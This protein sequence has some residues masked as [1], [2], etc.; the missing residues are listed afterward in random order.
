MNYL[1]KTKPTMFFTPICQPNDVKLISNKTRQ[2]TVSLSCVLLSVLADIQRVLGSFKFS[3][4]YP[5]A[6]T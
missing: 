3:L 1:D 5:F 6:D 4:W 2:M